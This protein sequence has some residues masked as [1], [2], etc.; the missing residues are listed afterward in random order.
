MATHDRNASVGANHG[1]NRPIDRV[2]QACISC[3]TAK[4]R[5]EDRKP[6]RR[7]QTK[8]ITCEVPP[9]STSRS[10]QRHWQVS[11]GDQ[12]L[13]DSYI[14]VSLTSQMGHTEMQPHSIL[15]RE[16]AVETNTSGH[17]SYTSSSGLEVS[18]TYAVGCTNSNALEHETVLMPSMENYDMDSLHLDP[19]QLV[20]DN[21]MDDMLFFSNGTDFNNQHIDINFHDFRFNDRDIDITAAMPMQPHAEEPAVTETAGQASHPT[22]NVRAGH[23]AF[24][25]SP[26]LWTPALKDHVFRDHEHLAIDDNT[27]ISSLSPMSSVN[28]PSCGF[29]RLNAGARDKMYYTVSTVDKYSKQSPEF[30]SLENLN[31][32]VE[33]FFLRQSYQ[34]DNWIHVASLSLSDVIPEFLIAL[35]IAGSAVISVPAIWKMGLALQDVVRV[36][37]G[38]LV[39]IVST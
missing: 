21:Q 11:M 9:S 29:P 14:G 28:V 4:A 8:N 35:V 25:R 12:G 19:T 23:A 32:I 27:T 17:Q 1:S 38:E 7:C 15:A 36:K 10:S 37:I 31:H 6:C 34:V 26:W 24:I 13:G 5:C 3:A 30:P 39:R 33:A 2:T 20:F 22:R 18:D 16:P